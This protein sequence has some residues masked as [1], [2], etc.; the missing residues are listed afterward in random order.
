MGFRSIDSDGAL[1]EALGAKLFL[2]FKHSN[3]CSISGRAMGVLES[4]LTEQPGLNAGVLDVVAERALAQAAA[5]QTGVPHASPQA[6]LIRDGAAVW[7]AS[8][9][10]I[11][12]DALRQATLQ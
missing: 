12:T 4:F 7:D 2:L 10:D 6:I 1:E 5:Q 11:T 8:H 3:R 9:F